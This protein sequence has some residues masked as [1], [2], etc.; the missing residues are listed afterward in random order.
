MYWRIK[1]PRNLDLSQSLKRS[2]CNGFGVGKRQRGVA[3]TLP[4]L[5]AEQFLQIL[6]V[7]LVINVL[8]EIQSCGVSLHFRL[9]F[10]RFVQA[11]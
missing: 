8:E 4:Q 7:D 10:V 6:I 2:N 9:R 5:L 1:L 11:P 3:H